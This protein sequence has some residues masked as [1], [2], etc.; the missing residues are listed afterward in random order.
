MSNIFRTAI[1]F[2]QWKYDFGNQNINIW[3][4]I[5]ILVIFLGQQ[6]NLINGNICTEQSKPHTTVSPKITLCFR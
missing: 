4:N 6:F 3:S 2:E 1:Q 5:L